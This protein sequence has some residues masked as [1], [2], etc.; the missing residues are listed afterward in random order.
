MD[1]TGVA[2]AEPTSRGYW[3][4]NDSTA[5]GRTADQAKGGK[6]DYTDRNTSVLGVICSDP[7]IQPHLR[8]LILPKFQGK[9]SPPAYIQDLYAQI[10][11]P[12]VVVHGTTG[13]NAD[14]PFHLFLLELRKVVYAVDPEMW[15]LLILDNC[16][17]H[18][19]R[20]NLM[21]MRTLGFV[22]LIIPARLTWLL[23]ML[24]VYVFA[25]FKRRL[26]LRTTVA[27]VA[28]DTCTLQRGQWIPLMGSVL[29][30]VLVK[31]DWQRTFSKCG[32]SS[33]ISLVNR[34]IR[35]FLERVPNRAPAKP[36]EAE[37]RDL[38]SM[39]TPPQRLQ[40]V[41][42]RSL[43]C[44]FPEKLLNEPNRAPYRAE[45]LTLQPGVP[46]STVLSTV[47]DPVMPAPLAASS[48]AHLALPAAAGSAAGPL[49]VNQTLRLEANRGTGPASNTRAQ[50]KARLVHALPRGTRLPG[51]SS[52][53]RG[54]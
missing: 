39:P 35:A 53:S 16:R 36:T 21:Y 5:D 4:A 26:R 24:D 46:P 7:A 48:S 49:A 2:H 22:V 37:L 17:V 18:V 47:F 33:D 52:S 38:L 40:R 50:A 10:G 29:Q 1:E 30:E 3:I 8:Q 11:Y 31:S 6:A 45:R 32:L 43:L 23:Q 41:S 34:R 25:E 12:A 51:A 20:K 27:K 28:A 42:W 13:W 54:P 15:I 9:K 44:S 19:N 14:K